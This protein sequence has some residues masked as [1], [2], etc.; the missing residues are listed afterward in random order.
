MYRY[1]YILVYYA[2]VMYV[3]ACFCVPKCVNVCGHAWKHGFMYI[4]I[5]LMCEYYSLCIHSTYQ[6]SLKAVF[7]T[8]LMLLD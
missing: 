5:C 1:V 2:S 8:A 7:I 3:C 4:M 6:A